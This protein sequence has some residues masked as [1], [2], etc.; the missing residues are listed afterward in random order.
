MSSKAESRPMDDPFLYAEQPASK[1]QEVTQA[2]TR[3]SIHVSLY[4][5]G[6]ISAA[7][8]MSWVDLTATFAR[9]DRQTDLRT[10]RE[11]AL[12]SRSR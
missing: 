8:L 9:S 4:A 12:I 2:G 11:D 1:P 7:C 10:V 3:P 6:G 5:Y